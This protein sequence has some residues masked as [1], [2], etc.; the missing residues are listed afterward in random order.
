MLTALNIQTS[1]RNGDEIAHYAE[2]IEDDNMPS[3]GTK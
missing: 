3:Q 2:I 1:E